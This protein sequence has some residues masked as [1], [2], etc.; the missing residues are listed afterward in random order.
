L[1]ILPA[2]ATLIWDLETPTPWFS[3]TTT[4]AIYQTTLEIR[5]R[6]KGFVEV[7]REINSLIERSGISV[8]TCTVFVQHTSASLL[9]QE[10][11][12]PSVRRDLENWLGDLAPET[13]PWLHDD[14]GSDDMPAHAQSAITQTSEVVPITKGRLALGTWQGL[15]LWEHRAQGHLRRLVVH[16]QGDKDG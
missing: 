1:G 13:R 7:T 11:A 3:S 15:Y 16:V 2:L 4:M 5:T 9:I 8:G 12:D 14:E 6:G 10:N